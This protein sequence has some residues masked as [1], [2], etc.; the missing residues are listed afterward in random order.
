MEGYLEIR[1]L[2][3]VRR[4][5]RLVVQVKL[6][7]PFVICLYDVEPL[8]ISESPASSTAMVE[9]RYSLPQAVP[10]SICAAES[11]I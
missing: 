7:P 1:F 6:C 3:H 11:V 10:S 8:R 9:Q 5:S 2:G 4:F